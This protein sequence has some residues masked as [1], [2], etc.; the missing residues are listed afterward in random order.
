MP[1]TLTNRRVCCHQSLHSN[2]TAPSLVI[3]LLLL[4]SLILDIAQAA[5]QFQFN[6]GG[7]ALNGYSADPIALLS[8]DDSLYAFEGNNLPPNLTIGLTHRWGSEKG[9]SYNF[10]TGNG[11]F[12]V[13]LVFAEIYGPAQKN[14]RRRFDVF[15]EDDLA[16]NDLD[17]YKTI[18]ADVEYKIT[19]KNSKV[20]D[21]ALSIAFR[22]GSVE[23]PMIS[24]IVLR[25]SNGSEFSLTPYTNT[26]GISIAAEP[27]VSALWDHQAHAVAGGPYKGTDY[28]GNG[29]TDI[30]IDG[31]RSHSHYSNPET[32][33]SGRIVK[34]EWALVEGDQGSIISTSQTFNY[35]FPVGKSFLQLRVEDQTGDS[36]TAETDVTIL[37]VTAAGT[38]CYYYNGTASL[39]NNVNDEPRPDEGHSTNV[40]NFF[41]DT[42]IYGQKRR[43]DGSANIWAMR[44]VTN[45]QSVNT[46]QYVFSVKYRG[47]G[48]ELYVNEGKKVVGGDSNQDD[49]GLKSISATVTVSDA[50]VPMQILYYSGGVEDPQLALLVNGKVAPALAL[51][52]KTAFVLPTIASVSSGQMEP[53]GGS[54]LQITGTGFFNNITVTIGGVE[55]VKRSLISSTLIQVPSVPSMEEATGISPTGSNR[56]DIE[57]TVIISNNAGS[58]NALRISYSTNAK[59]GISWSQTVLKNDEEGDSLFVLKQITAIKIGPD[60]KYYIGAYSGYVSRMDIGKDLKVKNKCDSRKV[61]TGRIILGMAFNYRSQAIRLYV[62]TNTLYLKRIDDID[63]DWD[64]GAIE[65][66]VDKSIKDCNECLCYERRVISGLPVSAHD[67]GVNGLLFLANGDLLLS[68]GGSTNAGVPSEELGGMVE[69]PLSGAVLIAKLSLGDSF[70]GA[71]TYDNK[72]SPATCKQTGGFDVEIYASGFRNCFAL[73]QHSNGQIWATDN[74]PNRL[75]GAGSSSCNTQETFNAHGKDEVNMIVRGKFYGH[76]N[77][78]RG[79][80]KYNG[81]DATQPKLRLQSATTGIIE[82]TSNAFSGALQGQLI[83]SKYA[84]SGDGKTWRVSIENDDELTNTLPMSQFSGIVVEN[85]LYGELLM[86]KVQKGFISVLQPVYS[87]TGNAP[88]VI[89]ISPNR[90]QSGF[91]VFISGEGF[92]DD[93]AV[94]FGGMDASNVQVVDSNGLFCVVPSGTGSVEID[95]IVGGISSKGASGQGGTVKYIYLS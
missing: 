12:D 41:Q 13:D 26:D 17:V 82:Y 49:D 85:G 3:S 86:P 68:V 83:L 34:Y 81:D 23:N 2:S 74:G 92:Q 28:N 87:Y 37:P 25:S 88:F 45:F 22:K 8:G 75:Y 24:A 60:S 77:R 48:A 9:F 52:Y 20:N 42:F 21:G 62:T 93:V 70:D 44:C 51:S 46:T 1:H 57:A 95:V 76:P 59:K 63:T 39:P 40:I 32:G 7:Y 84:A 36:A 73:T 50:T 89:A 6:C 18:G 61:G 78:N 56:Q 29:L 38:Y 19:V 33:D 11:Q 31:R 94:K 16:V 79:Q 27:I 43:D 4:V 66:F 69:T 15:I 10:P 54:Q 67:H 47:A 14:S 55:I 64:N 90:G 72:S 71:I 53:Q 80:C 65:T 91:Q 5:T 30:F 35:A 58:S